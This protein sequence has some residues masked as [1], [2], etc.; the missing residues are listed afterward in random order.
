M[1]NRSLY[2]AEHDWERRIDDLHCNNTHPPCFH[3]SITLLLGLNTNPTDCQVHI[4]RVHNAVFCCVTLRTSASRSKS[5]TVHLVHLVL[6]QLDWC[7]IRSSEKPRQ[8]T[9]SWYCCIPSQLIPKHTSS[10]GASCCSMRWI[11]SSRGVF[12]G[13][14][15]WNT[16]WTRV[17]HDQSPFMLYQLSHW[18]I[19]TPPS[20]YRMLTCLYALPLRLYK[21]SPFTCR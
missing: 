3:A 18:R 20:Q 7:C 17:S 19:P 12:V 5:I 1:K 11:S 10:S 16:K 21:D 15:G 9:T 13:G 14:K 2:W 6:V 8:P 4:A